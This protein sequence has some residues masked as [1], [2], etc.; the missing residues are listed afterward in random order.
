MISGRVPW[1]TAIFT[2]HR[3]KRFHRGRKRFSDR[4]VAAFRKV[5]WI[6][7][8]LGS[9][10]WET[11]EPCYFRAPNGVFDRGVVLRSPLLGVLRKVGMS[12]RPDAGNLAAVDDAQLRDR[13]RGQE[14]A[15]I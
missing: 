15:E 3:S 10:V 7:E 14:L 11:H 9:E 13:E 1:T 6:D 8:I 12:I 4:D 5:H 2:A